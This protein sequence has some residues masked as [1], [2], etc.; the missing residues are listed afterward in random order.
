[1]IL[2]EQTATYQIYISDFQ[3]HSVRFIKDLET[4]EVN[5]NSEDKAK[6]LG[7]KS[8]DELIQSD[9][10]LTNMFLDGLNS[11]TIKKFED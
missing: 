11:G 6:V 10:D 5:V 7:F 4:G 3:G 1:M 9:E 8:F 2:I